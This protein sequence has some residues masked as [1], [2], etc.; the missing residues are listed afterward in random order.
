[1]QYY[2]LSNII[3]II[4]II[5]GNKCNLNFYL[6]VNDVFQIPGVDQLRHLLTN[7]GVGAFRISPEKIVGRVDVQN[8][9]RF[10]AILLAAVH[11]FD[12][13]KMFLERKKRTAKINC[14]PY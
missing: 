3:G 5:G 8:Y 9:L 14:T 1:M 6:F 12:V 4:N 2:R 11:Q 10:G 13:E 7:D